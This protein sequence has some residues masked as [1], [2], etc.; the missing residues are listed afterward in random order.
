MDTRFWGPSGWL[1]LHLIAFQ[2]PKRNLQKVRTFFEQLPYVLPCKFCR[3]SLAEYLAD[4]PIPSKASDYAKW[5][6]RIHNRVNDKLRSQ[7]LLE[8]PNPSWD[9]VKR[10][11]EGW[12]QSSCSKHTMIGWDFL[13]SIA[14][15]TPCSSVGTSPMPNAPPLESLQTPELRNRWGRMSREERIPYLE[16]WWSLLPD[17]LPYEEWT[18][19]WKHNVPTKPNVEEG[20]RAITLWL[21]QVEKAMC[22][23]DDIMHASYSDLCSELKTFAS[24]CSKQRTNK[25][26]TCRA[27]KHKR[28]K[29]FTRRKKQL[30]SLTGGFLQ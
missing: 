18:M 8:T 24:G 29:I 28:R 14:Y 11:Y 20:R 21:F 27:I 22:T 9:D 19:R 23:N 10:R 4:D 26:K 30:Y 2:A 16:S 5:L 6:Y 3:A 12:I 7:K 15:T 17:V 1:L 25:M 13:F